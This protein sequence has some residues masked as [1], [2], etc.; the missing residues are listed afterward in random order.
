MVSVCDHA[1]CVRL[2]DV[3]CLICCRIDRLYRCVS[4]Q[5]RTVCKCVNV[6]QEKKEEIMCRQI[7]C[8]YQCSGVYQIEGFLGQT[9][10]NIQIAHSHTHTNTDTVKDVLIHYPYATRSRCC[11]CDAS[12]SNG[13]TVYS[14]I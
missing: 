1:L 14:V 2:W 6:G 13:G 9:P 7:H 8:W 12:D 4:I 10:E 11:I 3:V 5:A